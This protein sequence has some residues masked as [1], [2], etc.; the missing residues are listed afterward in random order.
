MGS[1]IADAQKKV[2]TI[3]LPDGYSVGWTGQFE[4]QQRAS[5]RLAQVVPVSIL[6]IFFLLFILF[7]NMKDSLLVL[8]NVPFALIGGIIA[9]HVTG[10]NF[11]ISAGVGM[12]ALLGICI[13]N[14]VI[15]ITEFH[16]NVKN[17]LDLDNA[18]LN[19]VKSRTRPVIM[20]ALM[21]SIGLMPAALSTG[22]GSESQKPLAIVII[23][24]LITA[25]V[26]T[27]LIFPIIFWI[28]N[29]TKRLSQA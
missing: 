11:G 14:G 18:I 10:I 13:Q 9:L 20:T 29:R 17:G 6:M 4:N 2:A 7:G 1:T 19:G 27:L 3:E 12:I 28:F 21:A 22:I 24:G 8:A 23:G 25:T 26:L 16:Q 5:H 15:L